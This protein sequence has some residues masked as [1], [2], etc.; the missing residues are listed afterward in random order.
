MTVLQAW[1]ALRKAADNSDADSLERLSR[2]YAA[3]YA[4]IQPEIDALTE[5]ITVKT[6]DGAKLTQAELKTSGVYRALISAVNDEL[7]DYSSYLRTEIRA[8]ATESARLGARQGSE[9]LKYA[10]ALALGVTVRSLPPDVI[11]VMAPDSLDFLREYLSPNGVLFG[12]IDQLAPYHSKYIADGILERVALGQN[13]R[14]IADWITDAYGMGLTDSL[15]MTR[16]VQL[17][18]YR[19]SNNAVQ[20]ANS[21]LLQGVV[22]S[23]ELDDRVCMSC[24]ALHGKVFPVGTIANDHHNGRCA[25]LP[26]VKGTPNPIEQSGAEWFASQPETT[27]RTMMGEGMYNNYKDGKF[28]VTD[29]PREYTDDVYGEMRRAATLKELVS[30]E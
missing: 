27:Q 19:Q 2:A 5:Y 13:P 29:I 12:K 26:W 20:V 11:A 28:A 14:I 10:T 7:E 25:M 8:A 15:R 30:D 17:Y 23:A 9:L 16:T 21:D 6:K 24:V 22:W 3:S 1:E 4:D 18:S